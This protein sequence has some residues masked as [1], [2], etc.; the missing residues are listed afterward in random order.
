M[1]LPAAVRR[2]RENIQEIVNDTR[3]AVAMQALAS[4]P[5]GFLPWSSFA[6][7]PAAIV[8]VLS[9]I[10]M[11]ERRVVVECGSGNSTVYV[12]R[13]LAQRGEGHVTTLDHDEH[14][15][16]M[17]AATLEREALT[18][19]ATV[20]HA[21]LRHGWYDTQLVPDVSGIDLL[22]VDGPPS[23]RADNLQARSPALDHFAARLARDATI[24]LD[25][26]RRRGERQTLA[27]WTARHNRTFQHERGGYAISRPS[28]IDEAA[29]RFP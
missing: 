16:R 11:F 4:L 28:A 21:P 24:V 20:V 8:G 10:A 2:Q 25:D 13:L 23:G 1:Q 22:V 6:M 29:E 5:G 18:R 17:T 15:A 19:W 3:D 26:A 9:D 27:R 7:R 14:W 12:A